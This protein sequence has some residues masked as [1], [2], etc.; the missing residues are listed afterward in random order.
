MSADI[1]PLD[2]AMMLKRGVHIYRADSGL[3][4]ID[5]DPEFHGE[6]V[7]TPIMVRGERLLMEMQAG[8]YK[9]NKA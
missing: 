6:S 7:T 2:I 8:K 5:D 1:T 4:I 9:E 3:W